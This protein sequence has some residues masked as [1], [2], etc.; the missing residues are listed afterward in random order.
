MTTL[1]P[2]NLTEYELGY[3]DAWAGFEPEEP[4]GDPV[5]A[6]DDYR[7]G[8]GV[9]IGEAQAFHEGWRA[10]NAGFLGCPYAKGSDDEVFREPFLLGYAAAMEASSL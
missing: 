10:H 1:A 8:W 9:G 6:G 2:K 3:D 7:F 4:I 5:L